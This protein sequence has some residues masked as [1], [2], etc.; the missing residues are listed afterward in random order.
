MR[1]EDWILRLKDQLADYKETVPEKLWEDI[2]KKL[3]AT[4]VS[5][6][7]KVVPMW[8]RVGVAAVL[9]CLVIGGV[10]WLLDMPTQ[11][12]SVSHTPAV[13]CKT[14]CSSFSQSSQ[15]S[16]SFNNQLSLSLPE[17][18]VRI[19]TSSAVLSESLS[20]EENA[21]D[22][23]SEEVVN[24]LEEKK[25]VLAMTEKSLRLPS[26]HSYKRGDYVRSSHSSHKGEGDVSIQLYAQNTLQS[27]T[28]N[29]DPVRMSAQMA[30]QYYMQETMDGKRMMA[31]ICL[32]GYEECAKHYQPISF[33]LSIGWR[34]ADRWTLNSGIVYTKASS[35]FI[36]VMGRNRL[37]DEQRLHYVGVPLSVSYSI[38]RGKGFSAYVQAG[39]QIDLNVD[40]ATTT[41]GTEYEIR[42]DRPQFSVASSAGVQYDVFPQLGVYVEPG[43]RYYLDNNSQID[44]IF[45]DKPLEFG[46]QLGLRWNLK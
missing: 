34:F 31:P 20:V 15:S 26:H 12:T 46:L 6:R 30:G 10:Y 44:N 22:S 21:V 40:A 33:G 41:N 29:A 1:Q 4:N 38:W 27:E 25:D 19:D 8:R 3:P 43:V 42:K 9:L 13:S 23:Q 36:H 18:F 24:S 37:V 2:E 14:I 32:V 17:K 39:G 45:K 16:Q 11:T 7:N 28:M 5:C 35:D